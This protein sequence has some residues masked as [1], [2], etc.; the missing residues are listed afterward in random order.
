MKQEMTPKDYEAL[1]RK[2]YEQRRERK[3]VVKK[4]AK[5]VGAGVLFVALV[6]GTTIMLIGQADLEKSPNNNH[7]VHE[8][9]PGEYKVLEEDRLN[10]ENQNEIDQSGRARG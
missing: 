6:A 7:I 3:E 10:D 9:T 4:L 5:Q 8:M 2:V 1:G